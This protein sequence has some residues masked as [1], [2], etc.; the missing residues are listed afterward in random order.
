MG[1]R[2]ITE[3]AAEWVIRSR[4]QDFADPSALAAWCA[5]DP[6]HAEAFERAQHLWTLLGAV[7][8]SKVR[9]RPLRAPLS[10]SRRAALGA[11][12]AG[13]LALLG[14]VLLPELAVSLRADLRTGRNE[15]LVKALADGTRIELD[16]SSAVQLAFDEHER[17]VVLLRGQAFFQPAPVSPGESRPFVVE[18]R[19]GVTRAVGTSFVVHQLAR[20][21]DVVAVEHTVE[22]RTRGAA[23]SS[24]SRTLSPG[25]ALRYTDDGQVDVRST[26]A[27]LA[28]QWRQERF[29][30][31]RVQLA[32]ACAV[33]TR[34]HA[35]PVRLLRRSQAGR[36]VSGAF[37]TRQ[38]DEAIRMI[39]DRYGLRVVQV[40]LAGTFLL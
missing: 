21:V 38:P 8:P 28:T 10:R 20:S 33:L 12:A 2:D 5:E 13:L 25:Q 40:P 7:P 24:G 19:N 36:L 39:A 6:R 18:C 22:V 27:A 34:Y 4:Q 11:M 1:A 37:D 32:D 14:A 23:A 31:D 29:V 9:V 16:A 30:L 17:R 3:E 26:V 35:R 15:R